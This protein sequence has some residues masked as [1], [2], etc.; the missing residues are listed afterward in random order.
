MTDR[1]AL[2]GLRVFGRHGVFDHER[3]DGQDFVV[4]VVLHVDSADIT[5]AAATDDLT[6]TVD[7]GTLADRLAEVVAGEPVNLLETLAIRLADVCLASPLVLEAEVTV[8]KPQ[9]PIAHQFSDVA[10]TVVRR[11]SRAVLAL[12]ANLGDRMGA[13]QRAVEMLDATPSVTVLEVSPVYETAPVGPPQPDYLNAVVVVRTSLGSR[14]LLDVAHEI[15]DELGRVRA[16]RFGPRT[17]DVDVLDFGG[18]RSDDPVLTLP[19]PRAHER[20]FVLVPWHD[21]DPAAEIPGRGR[22]ADLLDGVGVDG[23]RRREDLRLKT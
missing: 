6:H 20:A 10:V 4:D 17:V 22:I 7:Y 18:E 8:H 3:R 2:T 1:I 9:A 23:V 15:E 11:A 12:G 16:E 13:L 21:I 19:H 5:T 14:A